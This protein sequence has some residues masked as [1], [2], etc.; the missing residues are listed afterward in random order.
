MFMGKGDSKLVA[1][2][3]TQNSLC[4]VSYIW[5][6]HFMLTIKVLNSFNSVKKAIIYSGGSTL[7]Y[8]GKSNHSL[9]VFH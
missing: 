9:R 8:L 6:S 5:L 3:Q 1:V 4:F 2:N 7:G